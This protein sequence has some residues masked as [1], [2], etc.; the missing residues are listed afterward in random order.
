MAT[1]NDAEVQNGT[2]QTAVDALLGAW[3][4]SAAAEDDG[5]GRRA[6]LA[7]GRR[8]VRRGRRLG[9]RG[10][11][12]DSGALVGL[13]NVQ[14]GHTLC[15]PKNPATLEPMMSVFPTRSAMPGNGCLTL[16]SPVTRRP[17]PC[18]VV[19][20]TVIPTL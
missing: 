14:T 1:A 6:L 10:R 9:L 19:P 5:W 17:G 16:L 12:R 4:R 7:V 15:D 13:K 11:S 8:S 20:G 18:A 3:R 2:G